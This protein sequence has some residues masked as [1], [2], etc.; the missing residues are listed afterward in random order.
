MVKTV[1]TAL[2]VTRVLALRLVGIVLSFAATFGVA[3][4][5]GATTAT[6][7][8]FLVRRT[9]GSWT[10]LADSFSEAI[11]V[12]DLV[13]KGRE[14]SLRHVLDGTLRLER[15]FLAVGLVFAVLLLV[16]PQ[17]IVGLIAPGLDPATGKKAAQFFAIVAISLP[18]ILSTSLIGATLQSLRLFSLPVAARLLPRVLI[19]LAL[20]TVPFGGGISWVVVGLLVGHVLTAVV[21]Y[22][23]RS[24]LM[25]EAELTEAVADTAPN[26][27]RFADT[28]NR[29]IATIALSLYFLLSTLSESYFASFLAVGTITALSLG[30]R[31]S[32]IATVE[33]VKSIL[34]VNYTDFSELAVASPTPAQAEA[35]RASIAQAIRLALFCVAPLALGLAALSE[36]VS[37]VLLANGNFAPDSAL[38]VASFIVYFSISTVVNTPASILDAVI[39]SSRAQPI[40]RHYVITS[41]VALSIRIAIC[42]LLL[43]VMGVAAIGLAAIAGPLVFLVFNAVRVRGIVGPVLDPDQTRHLA[44]IFVAA[45]LASALSYA[46]YST[47][48]AGADTLW[49]IVG[50]GLGFGALGL[51]YMALCAAFR[52]PEALAILRKLGLSPSVARPE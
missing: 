20:L 28:R 26:P 1:S 10:L 50:L 25:R 3:F 48:F 22:R 32:T 34:S 9:I 14:T 8:F 11:F 7:A 6:D 47:L 29:V 17:F 51:V 12:P 5:F 2:S 15:R 21:I 44:V 23:A 40:A 49:A 36:P 33:V 24:K 19:L 4:L 30:Q 43:P 42:M 38:L 39:L 52:L 18:L 13:A 37:L 27:A 45:I 35:L 46:G 41:A 31:I 16:F